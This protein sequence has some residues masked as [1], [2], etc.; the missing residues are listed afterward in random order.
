MKL[1]DKIKFFRLSKNLTQSYVADCLEIDTGNYSRLERG[2]T[3]ISIERLKKIAEILDVELNTL[4]N[5]E[6]VSES[7][8]SM[9]HL[10]KEI[11]HEIKAINQKLGNKSRTSNGEYVENNEK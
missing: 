3:K 11:L 1:H 7:N 9:Q 5:N 2:E 8:N 10:I 4:M 6:T